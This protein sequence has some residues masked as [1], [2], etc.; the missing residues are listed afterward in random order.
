MDAFLQPHNLGRRQDAPS[1][2][3]GSSGGGT[4]LDLISNPFQAAVSLYS[5]NLFPTTTDLPSSN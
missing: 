1:G 2:N 3:T 4:F 5:P